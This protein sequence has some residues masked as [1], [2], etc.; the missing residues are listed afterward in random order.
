MSSSI[1]PEFNP[2]EHLSRDEVIKMAQHYI[3][4]WKIEA[5]SFQY[6]WENQISKPPETTQK[7]V[8]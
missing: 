5:Q 4:Y 8:E 3:N 7:C 1:E 6:K 2:P